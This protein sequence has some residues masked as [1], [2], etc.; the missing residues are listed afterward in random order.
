MVKYIYIILLL[1]TYSCSISR[2]AKIQPY[3]LK[4][5]IIEGLE[6]D[7]EYNLNTSNRKVMKKIV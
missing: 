7:L 1:I 2:N 3:S 5:T 6:S 4:I